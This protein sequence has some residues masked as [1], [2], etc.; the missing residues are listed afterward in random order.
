MDSTHNMHRG[1][2]MHTKLQ[3]G[4]LKGGDHCRNFTEVQ[5]RQYSSSSGKGTRRDFVKMVLR[6]TNKLWIP[7]MAQNIQPQ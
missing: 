4:N 3:V 6:N 5:S 2:Q 7:Q 1:S